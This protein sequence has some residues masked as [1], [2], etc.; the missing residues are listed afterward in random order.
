MNI[1]SEAFAQNQ[2]VE[3]TVTGGTGN[4]LYQ[5]DNGPWVAQNVFNNIKGCDVRV[6]SVQEAS[7]CNDV[8]TADF[9]ILEFPKFFTPNGDAFNETWNIDCLDDQ[10]R[11][12][13]SIFD[14]YGKLLKVISTLG[15]GWDG[16]YLG[17]PMPS[18]DYWFMVEY[19]AADDSPRTFRSHFTLKR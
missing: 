13:V 9:R 2:R 14:R 6:V 19:F 1:I 15:A 16:T 12:K 18:S 5:L 17:N 8:A 3:V 10:P 11:A 4:Y 7:G